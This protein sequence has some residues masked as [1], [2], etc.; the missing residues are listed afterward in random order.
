MSRRKYLMT[1]A[2]V[3]GVSLVFGMMLASGPLRPASAPSAASVWSPAIAAPGDNAVLA[4]TPGGAPS[5]FADV[6][7]TANK[8]VVSIANVE[9]KTVRN[10]HGQGGPFGGGD[11]FEFFFGPRRN[12]SPQDDEGDDW[13][14]EQQRLESGGSG[15][16]ISDDGYILT[17]NHVVENASKLE[18]TLEGGRKLEARV[19]GTDPMIDLALIK[20]ESPDRLPT[21]PL[22]DSDALRVGEWVVAIGNPLVYEHTVTVGVVSGKGRQLQDGGRTDLSLANFIQT[23]AAINFG[24]SG[25]PLLNTRG[26][27]VG[28]N[29]AITRNYGP[30]SGLIQGIGFALP[31]NQ[32]RAVIDQLRDSGKVARGYLGVSISPVDD[33]A[34]AAFNLPEAAGALVQSVVPGL[35]GAEAG[36][37]EGDVITSIDG[38]KV[39]TTSELI[40]IVSSHKP[41]ETVALSII[42]ETKPTTIKV[43]LGDR[44]KELA[45]RAR[46]GGRDEEELKPGETSS[47]AD[48]QSERIGIRVADLDDRTAQMFELPSDHPKG[49]VVESVKPTS[50]AYEQNLRRGQIITRVNNTPIANARDFRAAISKIR[51]GEYAKLYTVIFAS[52]G[53]VG[54]FV[55]VKLDK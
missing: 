51:P 38:R 25:G 2:L 40:R 52:D 3:G 43:R 10:P 34:R 9:Y 11:P 33:D 27:V 36:L 29:T 49:V 48:D 20:I 45:S 37:R 35:P 46:A 42:R 39:Q 19:V 23:D 44:A 41:G 50:A 15:F 47:E 26:E 31:I 22:G 24:N 6:A 28:I 13:G 30:Y 53:Q 16:I 1:L 5:T 8:A 4:G 21:I 14:D 32:A 17:N 7:E 54:R 18:V 55:I 12:Q